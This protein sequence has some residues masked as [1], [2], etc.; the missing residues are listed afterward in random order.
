MTGTL[1]HR[2]PDD[3]G[4]EVL[5]EHGV[6]L[7]MRRLTIIDPETGRQ[8]IWNED[9]TVCVVF[10]GEIYNFRELRARLAAA[11]H[12]FATHH[13]DT[14]V[15]VH[16]YEEWGTA[17]FSRLNG[18]FACAIWDRHRSRLVL[19][20]DRVGE[21]PLYIAALQ[22]GFAVGSELKALLAHSGV[23][24][25][26]D[27]IALDQY[28]AFD[29]TLAPRTILKN[30]IKL[31]AAHYA[32]INKDGYSAFPYWTPQCSV[33][34]RTE[35]EALQAL[36]TLL[37]KSVG[38]RMV[39]D[40]PVGVFLSGGVDSSTIAY[41]MRRHSDRV[42]S[43]SIGFD[44]AAYDESRY[45]AL[46]SRHIGTD[47][48]TEILSA[49]RASELL[50]T[51]P[52]IL[53]EPMADSSILP[54]L[55]LSRF[56]RREVKVA[57][58]GD[59]SDELLMGYR[60]Y[61]PL[62]VA[63]ELERM[64]LSLRRVIAGVAR[65]T[66]ASVGSRGIRGIQFLRRIDTSASERLLSHLGSYKGDARWLLQEHFRRDL[67]STISE[68][69][70]RRILDGVDG[71]LSP[72]D[73][74]VIGYVRSYL[75]EDILVKVDRASMATS[76]EVRS[77][78]LDP[79][80]LDF[81]LSLPASLKMKG[82][83]RKH[84]LRALMRGRLP[85]AIIDRPKQGFG[86]PIDDWLRKPL[87]SVVRDYLGPRRLAAEGIFDPATVGRLVDWHLS[88]KRD[89]GKELWLLLQFQLWK[90]RWLDE[91]STRRGTLAA[92]A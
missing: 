84:L 47:H 15:L 83:R 43:F 74:T 5:S 18:M 86:I 41:Y 60:A 14:E 19:A 49:K 80:F 38:T 46:A 25:E 64:P 34:P 76:L 32:V 69:P 55:L 62:K 53:D 13:S 39:A 65:R 85:D 30:V 67:P 54:T 89:C 31:P 27:P 11:G 37:D 36:D 20:R 72:A 10:N 48:H 24:R 90:E 73:E 78:F 40:V 44:E 4:V 70:R 28:L 26:I 66:P 3:I 7:G 50:V 68:E 33:A 57:L 16:G 92:V 9:R 82:L 12:V 88:G 58:G 75:Q 35:E 1:V 42:Q 8:P 45:A 29:Y 77:P 17:L 63:W 51:I 52:E 81:T 2:G 91:P 22:Q 61:Q 21:K 23:S 59:G 56:A 71:A 79:E 6:A 87:S